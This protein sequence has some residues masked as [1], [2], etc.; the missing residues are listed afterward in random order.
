MTLQQARHGLVWQHGCDTTLKM[1]HRQ[2]QGRRLSMVPRCTAM[3]V[4]GASICM[5]NLAK[6]RTMVYSWMDHNGIAMQLKG[7][8]CATEKYRDLYENLGQV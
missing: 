7:P 1:Q 5:C 6:V 2:V 3:P 8:K 4:R